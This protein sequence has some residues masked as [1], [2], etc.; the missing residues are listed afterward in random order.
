MRTLDHLILSD[1]PSEQTASHFRDDERI[2]RWEV[3]NFH[4][5]FEID[6]A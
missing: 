3:V 5:I 4:G 6:R 1:A 2:H